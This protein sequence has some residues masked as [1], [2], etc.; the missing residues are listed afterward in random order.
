[1]YTDFYLLLGLIKLWGSHF[2]K[3]FLFSWNV[4]LTQERSLIGF[5]IRK[6]RRSWNIW[7]SNVNRAKIFFRSICSF[8]HSAHVL[9]EKLRWRLAKCVSGNQA[10]VWLSFPLFCFSWHVGLLG[11]WGFGIWGFGRFI[12]FLLISFSRFQYFNLHFGSLKH[13][14]TNLVLEI[15]Y[16]LSLI[17][18]VLIRDIKLIYFT[19]FRLFPIIVGHI[20]KIKPK[21]V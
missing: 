12:L 9:C 19:H 4:Q 18:S 6:F 15:Q 16:N 7:T 5:A 20:S 10:L 13:C 3:I 21:F 8:H 11:F 2:V 17:F 1:M 14:F